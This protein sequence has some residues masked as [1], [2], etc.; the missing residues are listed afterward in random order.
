MRKNDNKSSDK[1]MAMYI[2][3][4]PLTKKNLEHPVGMLF[5]Y[6]WNNSSNPLFNPTNSWDFSSH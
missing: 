6:D 3:G 1:M 5:L 2:F 4:Y